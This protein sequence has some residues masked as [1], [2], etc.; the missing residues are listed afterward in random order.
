MGD[1][2]HLYLYVTPAGGRHWRMNYAYGEPTKPGG[3]MPQKTLSLG[4]YPALTLRDARCAMCAVSGARPRLRS[5]KVSTR[6]SS[7][8]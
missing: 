2:G 3:R 8:R 1:S 6:R 5:P 4:S 7:A